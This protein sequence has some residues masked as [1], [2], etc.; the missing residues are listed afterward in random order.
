MPFENNFN[1]NN[2][3]H[4]RS[5]FENKL[6]I[7]NNHH[8]RTL[9][10]Q[11]DSSIDI[12]T[13]SIKA[14]S[15]SF[16]EMHTQFESLKRVNDSLACFNEAFGSFLFGMAANDMTLEWKEVIR[17]NLLFSITPSTQFYVAYYRRNHR[18]AQGICETVE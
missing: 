12:L 2:S 11:P 18:K 3:H 14:I 8:H 9:N 10:V 17:K 5:P 15:D 6:N 16:K 4:R 7:N 1:T 13:P